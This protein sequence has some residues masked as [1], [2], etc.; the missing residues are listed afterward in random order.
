[1]D[2]PTGTLADQLAEERTR[3][4]RAEEAARAAD[5]LLAF[6][7]HELRS[8]L[9]AILGWTRVLQSGPPDPETLTHGL[10]AI[11]R[12]VQSQT[13]TL[14]DLLDAVRVI[15]GRIALNRQMVDVHT[16]VMRARDSVDRLA[17]TRGVHLELHVDPLARRLAGD[18]ERLA[19]VITHLLRHAV[20]QTPAGG[21]VE[22][23]AVPSDSG[24]RVSVHDSGP[25]LPP[26]ELP[27]VF[28]PFGLDHGEPGRRRAGPGLGLAV[29]RTLVELH[30]GRV[31]ATSA[32]ADLGTTLVVELP[33]GSLPTTASSIPLRTT[34]TATR[35][36]G[37]VILVA[38]DDPHARDAMRA[39]LE[40]YGARVVAAASAPEALQALSSREIDPARAVLVADIGMP[41]RDGYWLI[42][43]VRELDDAHGGRIPAVA[44]TGFGSVRDRISALEAGYQLHLT[45]PFDPARLA[46]LLAGLV[47]ERTTL[48]P[49]HR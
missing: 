49:V 22:L 43:K 45:K 33:R 3:R 25:G 1:M 15:G 47:D 28:E 32:G 23:E 9:N 36:R 39:A 11:A 8:P 26:D 19:Q 16:V 2:E 12:S 48:P 18:P 30:G 40:R 34:P 4:V 20:T 7:S 6:V 41:D 27:Q 21:R 24:I 17:Q 5:E 42:R 14:T 35:L 44:L 29:A 13:D 37:V 46:A 31:L 38:E 10:E